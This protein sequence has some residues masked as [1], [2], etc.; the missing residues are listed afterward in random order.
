MDQVNTRPR[1]YVLTSNLASSYSSRQAGILT[2]ADNGPC[3]LIGI[4]NVLSLRGKLSLPPGCE[5]RQAMNV[6]VG[7]QCS[8]DIL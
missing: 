2:Q 4:V 7:G 6:R 1:H 8:V 3:P 5:V